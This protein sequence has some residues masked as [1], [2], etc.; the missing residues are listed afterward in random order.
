MAKSEA[1]A[2][3]DTFQERRNRV[4]ELFLEVRA[5]NR[6]RLDELVATLT[7]VLWQVARA[8]GLDRASSQDVVQMTWLHFLKDIE[9][10]HTPAAVVGWL[11]T[12]TKREAWRMR[13]AETNTEPVEG[14]D[15]ADEAATPEEA[16]V[17][18]DEHRRLWEA[19]GTLSR[20]CQ[21]LLR[22]VA[23]VPR[24]SYVELA[25]RL[26]MPVGGVGPTRGRCLAQ[27]RATLAG[28]G[29]WP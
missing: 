12:T 28:D 16:V 2:P 11:V 14:F 27:L 23:F 26:G 15:K 5:G 20:R 9:R 10:I 22:V 7:P 24:P 1:T 18:G 17:L 13:R 19:V 29:G 25:G 8:Q 3:R 21:E 6:D 4:A